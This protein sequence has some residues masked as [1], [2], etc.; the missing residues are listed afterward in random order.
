MPLII[1]S[2]MSWS[3][4]QGYKWFSSG[5]LVLNTILDNHIAFVQGVA[6]RTSQIPY[7][8]VVRGNINNK[9]KVKR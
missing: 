4:A 2:G 7:Q 1:I 3:V 6:L 9:S 8:R 5:N